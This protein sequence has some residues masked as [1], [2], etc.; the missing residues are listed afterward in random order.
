MACEAGAA[1]Y[2]VDATGGDDARSGLSPALAWQTL[3]KVNGSAFVADDFVLLKR[4]GTWAEQLTPPSSGASSHPITFGA[5][6]SGNPP[7]ITGAASGVNTN[8]KDYLTFYGLMLDG[9]EFYVNASTGT[10]IN[11]VVVKN[12][13]ANGINAVNAPAT[14]VNNCTLAGNARSGVVGDGATTVVAVRNT[15]V[16]GN[17]GSTPAAYGGIIA[18]NAAAVSYDHSIV[19]GNAYTASLNVGAGVTDG[20]SNQLEAF[21]GFRGYIN[22]SVRY[23]FTLDDYDTTYAKDISAVFLPYNGRFTF[24]VIGVSINA[25][26]KADLIALS[27][28]GHEIA[29]HTW[30]HASATA[31]NAFSITSTNA[32]PTIQVDVAGATIT[33]SC[34]EVGNR[35]MYSTAAD[36]TLGGL[37]AAVAGKGWTITPLSSANV[38][39]NLKVASLADTAGAVAVPATML[40]DKV[41][42]NYAFWREEIT[43]MTAWITANIGPTPTTLSWP[44]GAWGTDPVLFLK[45]VEGYIGARAVTAALQRLNSV[46][47]FRT[48]DVLKQAD[49][50][51]GDGGEAAIRSR[52]RHYI[53]LSRQLGAVFSIFAHT[54]ADLTIA[55]VG[56][57][58]D[59]I[60]KA[61]GRWETFKDIVSSVRAGH[62]TVDGLTYTKSYADS[63]DFRLTPS[64]P[65]INAGVD[66]GLTTDI[67]GNQIAGLPDIG[68]HESGCALTMTLGTSTQHIRYY[69]SGCAGYLLN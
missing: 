59:E 66:L 19:T 26:K 10:T 30:S 49:Y 37:I 47:I 48:G 53:E 57:I 11:Y 63:S 42:P 36:S 22:G 18:T 21:P 46:P 27:T 45:D 4:G 50:L 20:G 35:V 69:P 51:L 23:L 3:A 1:T 41:A 39:N 13:T 5:Y 25:P 67:V 52:T 65:A 55:Q 14:A 24:F 56:W 17:G 29:N 58:T 32:N 43:D 34:D 8:A 28:A 62:S 15:I 38:G 44:S 9:R 68:A 54:T 6:D 12:S 16:S 7:R 40:L 33:L 2:Y 61:G 64:S 31:A 60:G